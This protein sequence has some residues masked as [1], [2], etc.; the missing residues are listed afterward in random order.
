MLW[1]SVKHL[2]ATCSAL[3]PFEAK[4]L[5]FL[6]EMFIHN[7]CVMYSIYVCKILCLHFAY[8][9]KYTYVLYFFYNFATNCWGVE[10]EGHL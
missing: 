8:V 5:D 10:G 3:S 9:C 7:I 4:F 6:I 1:D 2:T